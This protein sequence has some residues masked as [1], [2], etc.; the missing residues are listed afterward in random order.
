MQP[1]TEAQKA[2]RE[3]IQRLHALISRAAYEQELKGYRGG[4]AARQLRAGAVSSFK[5]E[6][7]LLSRK[8][9]KEGLAPPREET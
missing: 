7:N 2:R 4:S 3:R 8:E 1:I 6:L 9:E 5:R